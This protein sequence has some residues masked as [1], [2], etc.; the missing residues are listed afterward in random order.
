MKRSLHILFTT[1]VIIAATTFPTPANAF[2]T[3]YIE[4]TYYSCGSTQLVWKGY[5]STDC[6]GYYY[7]EGNVTPAEGDFRYWRMENCNTGVVR[8][9]WY[10][11]C[12]TSWIAMDGPPSNGYCYC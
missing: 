12:G 3:F 1:L 4:N 9:R 7:S 11:R 10:F 6:D 5:E 8:E 2:P